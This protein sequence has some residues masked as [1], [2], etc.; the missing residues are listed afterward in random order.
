MISRL[1][2]TAAATTGTPQAMNSIALKPHL[3]FDHSSSASG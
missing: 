3:P 1:T 2:P